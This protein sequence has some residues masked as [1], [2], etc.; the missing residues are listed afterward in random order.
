MFITEGNDKFLLFLVVPHRHRTLVWL[1][2]LLVPQPEI[3]PTPNA[4]EAQ[5][6]TRSPRIGKFQRQWKC[7]CTYFLSSK[8]TDSMSWRILCGPRSGTPVLGALDV[9]R[10]HWHHLDAA[11]IQ[12][13]NPTPDPRIRTTGQQKSLSYLCAHRNLTSHAKQMFSEVKATESCVLEQ[14]WKIWLQI[15]FYPSLCLL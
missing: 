7:R 14:D 15:C 1:C 9:D 6:T 11:E 5:R 8:F 12:D 10:Q 2:R 4:V 13:L 3:P